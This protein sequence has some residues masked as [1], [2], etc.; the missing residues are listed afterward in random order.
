MRKLR[1][2][3]T[4]ANGMVGRNLL[5]HTGIKEFDVLAPR[6]SE[7]NLLDFTA[8]KNY[9]AKNR[10][11]MVIHAAGKVGG[12]QANIREPVGFLLENL[13]MGRNIVLASYQTGTKRLLNLG[14]SCMYPRGHDDPLK[15][16]MILKGELEPTNEG[17]AL[18]KIV[19]ARLGEYIMRED[20]SFQ[21]KTIIPCNLYGRHDKFEPANSHLIPA[22]IHKVHIAKQS[23][24]PSVEIWGD[25][26]ARR[27]FMYA[28]DLADAIVRSIRKFESLPPI[29]N[30]GLGHDHT[31]NEYYQATAEV[32][33]YAGEFT[34]DL[35]K[36]V[37][38]MRKLV[39]TEQQLA[40]GWRPRH[41]LHDGIEKTYYY[42]LKEYLQ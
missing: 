15:E 42:Y 33:G 16:E 40:W 27:E 28:G 7:V 6:S 31:I 21:C 32:M 25:G 1:I 26:T 9:L 18:A 10:P 3:L 36:P 2:M 38:M 23:N 24:Q 29:I 4:G 11:D 8:V 34:H 12:I 35:E 41:G 30:I 20:A 14:S 19:A 5:E 22:I 37:G 13:D 17:Y 39:N